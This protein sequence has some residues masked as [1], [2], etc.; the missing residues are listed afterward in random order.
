MKRKRTVI[1]SILCLLLLW[2]AVQVWTRREPEGVPDAD[3]EPVPTPRVQE[4]L[5]RSLSETVALSEA[6]A[7]TAAA[8][9]EAVA[10]E[11]VSASS[12]LLVQV[13]EPDGRVPSG[14]VMLLSVDSFSPEIRQPFEGGEVLLEVPNGTWTWMAVSTE[15]GRVRMTAP[16]SL[17]L[18]QGTNG[19][20]QLQFAALPMGE[21]GIRLL[22]GELYATV[23]EVAAE[24]PAARAGMQPGDAVIAIGGVPAGGI[25]EQAL[26]RM[27]EG[28]RGSAVLLNLVIRHEDGSLEE[29]EVLLGR[30]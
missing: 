13:R 24:S 1:E 16:E 11:A 28:E 14:E 6:T 3:P 18:P 15:R 23:T 5:R 27:L 12:F 9:V 25:P 4:F 30:E 2:V 22:G 17:A 26:Q 29:V 21:P 7:E 19:F 20:L 10:G 8:P